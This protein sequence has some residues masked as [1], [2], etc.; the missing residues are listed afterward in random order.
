L[1]SLYSLF[2]FCLLL[3]GAAEGSPP[4]LKQWTV[5]DGLAQSQVFQIAQ[6]Q[7]GFLWIGTG[8]GLNRFDGQRI[9]PVRSLNGA[10]Y[11][12]AINLIFID[13]R[14]RIWVS[15]GSQLNALLDTDASE[16]TL[17]NLP[18][19]SPEQSI[20]SAAQQRAF[21]AASEDNQGIWFAS[22]GE[23]FFLPN[24]QQNFSFVASM[25]RHI[26][27]GHQIIRVL[28]TY[29]NWLLIGTSDGLWALPK[30][31][32]SSDIRPIAFSP[33]PLND[34]SSNVKSLYQTEQHLLVGTVEGL[35]ALPLTDLERQLKSGVGSRGLNPRAQIAVEQLNIWTI[36]PYKNGFLLATNDGV[37]RWQP[38]TQLKGKAE[39]LFRYADT[40]F[41][42]SDDDVMTLF[43]DRQGLIW[44]GSRN[45]GLFRWQPKQ[46]AAAYF[47]RSNSQ[48]SHDM[49]W[50]IRADDKGNLWIG[51]DNGLNKLHPQSGRIQTYLVNPD[52]RRAISESSIIDMEWI[53]N[54]LWLYTFEG[55]RV[56][57]A[58]TGQIWELPTKYSK[59]HPLRG[60]GFDLLPM[61]E[62]EALLLHSDGIF[63]IDINTLE[64]TLI[65][66]SSTRNHPERRIVNSLGEVPG[67]PETLLLGGTEGLLTLNTR[68][69]RLE[70]LHQLPPSLRINAHPQ[71]FLVVQNHWW[72]SYPGIGIVIFDPNTK[73][74]KQ[75]LGKKELATVSGMDFFTD[76]RNRIWLTSNEGLLEINAKTYA[77]RLLDIKDG[78][79]VSE[80]NGGAL[81]HSDDGALWLGSVKGVLKILPEE[82][83]S[84]QIDVQR[85]PIIS[86]VSLLTRTLPQYLRGFNNRS[87]ALSYDDLGLNI[88]FSALDF[89][90]ERAVYRYWLSGANQT[91]PLQTSHNE[92][93]FPKL[94][95]GESQFYVSVLNSSSGQYSPPAKLNIKVA[96]APWDTPLAW[97]LYW[98][99][100]LLVLGSIFILQRNRLRYQQKVNRLL[101]ESESRLQMALKATGS[102]PWHWYAE[103]N[104]FLGERY[105]HTLHDKR[106]TWQQHIELI[107]P[108]DRGF[109]RFK[110]HQLITG[111]LEVFEHSYRLRIDR[112][113]YRWFQDVG[114]TIIDDNQLVAVTG[115]Y[116][117]IT[118]TKSANDKVQLF[119]N[120]F[121]NSQDMVLVFDFNGR[122]LAGNQAFFRT[123]EYERKHFINKQIRLIRNAENDEN[124]LP[125]ILQQLQSSKSYQSEAILR[126]H[127]REPV[128][129]NLNATT[130]SQGDERIYV[131]V[132][133]TDITALKVAQ[134]KL[135]KLARYDHLTGLPNRA[136][137]MDRLERALINAKRR[138]RSLALMFID[139][140]HFKQVNDTLGHDIGDLLLIAVARILRSAVRENDTVARL[141]GDEFVILLE[142]VEGIDV[143]NRIAKSIQSRLR[144]LTEIEGHPINVSPSIGITLYPDNGQTAHELL[145]NADNA[146]YH[147]KNAGRNTFKYFQESMNRAAV[148]RMKLEQKLRHAVSNREFTLAY[149]PQ[150]RLSDNKLVG[151]EALARWTDREGNVIS[152]VRFI[153]VAEELGLILEITEQLISKAICQLANWRQQG[154]DVGVAAN[155]SARHLHH[156]DLVG[157][158]KPLIL[159]HNVP[160]GTF[161]LELTETVLMQDTVSVKKIFNEL[162]RFGV[163][164]A[165]DDFGTGY[166]SLKYLTELPIKKIKIDRSFVNQ[167]GINPQNELIIESV[168][169]LAQSLALTTVAEGVEHAK[170]LTYLK[171]MGVDYV[172]GY[173][174]GKPMTPEDASHLLRTHFA[175][176]EQ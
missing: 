156:Y 108:E 67:S 153:N 38:D 102:I 131:V 124:L 157:F 56:F 49:V 73:R 175:K 46:L 84:S 86:E 167:I 53:N 148:N 68:S 71:D 112:N 101:A 94:D 26:D 163:H 4:R 154:Y 147:A 109:Y 172:Q 119:F 74:I 31:G 8:Q 22:R 79:P 69:W 111:Q 159:E 60:G 137:L 116:V 118:D 83:P 136:L 160:E 42:T 75:I 87:L 158:I 81:W 6:D 58:Q 37:Y 145:K 130:F 107:H 55:L 45:D 33:L 54:K 13:S 106:A 3:I 123:T 63:R 57:D 166:S 164:L 30:N 24:D 170:Q 150:F 171:N 50:R 82:L 155:L 11:S 28:H 138:R 122:L 35:F 20:D 129:V 140:D 110:W 18:K 17:V 32:D 105:R 149:Q 162:S 89:S 43:E 152:P 165:L 48:L 64:T 52:E 62:Q 146:M 92:V 103:D 61:N 27:L 1:R 66:A 78:L 15:S 133:M 80:F 88:R 99:A 93:T 134:R 142:E 14:N 141:G 139:L 19:V 36:H 51:T 161:E 126:C 44:L 41:Y 121:E 135:E 85:P 10:L 151:F 7:Q 96:H 9:E 59:Y 114:R 174:T 40:P 47:N 39:R 91:R 5:E 2:L 128:T 104:C 95:A 100:A 25:H 117:D 21:Y 173:L 12:D 176:Q 169:A 70:V 115:T 77:S 29:K 34:L 127:Y 98:L 90:G 65:E 144:K 120:A 143:L 76:K 132:S 168:V 125:D 16:F 113:T 23:I 72:I 97:T